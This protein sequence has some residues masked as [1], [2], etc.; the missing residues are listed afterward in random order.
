MSIRRVAEPLPRNPRPPAPTSVAI[1]APQTIAGR[2]GI[3]KQ[4]APEKWPAAF[5]PKFKEVPVVSGTVVDDV[6][7][8]MGVHV[9]STGGLMD[10]AKSA[11]SGAVN[12]LKAAKDGADAAVLRAS[13]AN[14]ASAMPR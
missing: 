4:H 13:A 7:D 8:E 6:F 12:A 1:G 14:A 5:H 3:E 11:K 9:D 10:Y 2:L